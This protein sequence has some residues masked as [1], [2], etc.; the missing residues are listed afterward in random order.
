MSRN[1]K[2]TTLVSGFYVLGLGLFVWGAMLQPETRISGT[3]GKRKVDIPVYLQ[4][5]PAYADLK[6]TKVSAGWGGGR[7]LLWV[8][9]ASSGIIGLVLSS[10][11]RSEL[12]KEQILYESECIELDEQAKLDRAYRLSLDKA[13]KERTGKAAIALHEDATVAELDSLREAN[14]WVAPP[15]PEAKE[16]LLPPQLKNVP[17]SVTDYKTQLEE[18][19]AAARARLTKEGADDSEECDRPS[20][21]ADTRYQLY[22]DRGEK[23]MRSL[24]ALKMSILSAAPT[25]AGKTH[26][27]YRWLGDLQA[28]YPQNECYVIAHKRDSF[29]G[30]LEQNRVKL[31]DDLNPEASLVFLDKVY[32]EMKRRLGKPENERKKF[33]KLPIRLILDDW[34][35]SYGVIKLNGP[36]WNEVRVKL[37]AIITKGREANVCLYIA[38]QS[39][40]LEAIG[41]Q[42]SNIRGNLAITCQ[43][44]VT[45]KLDDY[46]DLV[47]QGNYESIQLLI[48]NKFIVSSRV[49]RERLNAELEELIALS[50]LHQV[51][52][53]FSAVGNNTLALAPYYEKPISGDDS[54]STNVA[55]VDKEELRSGVDLWEEFQKEMLKRQQQKTDR[56][57]ELPLSDYPQNTTSN[58]W[59]DAKSSNTSGNTSNQYQDSDN[60]NIENWELQNWY[61]WLPNKEEV[62]KLI[63]SL[64]PIYNLAYV[65]KNRLK[66]TEGFYNRRAKAAIVRLLLDTEREDLIKKLDIDPTLYPFLD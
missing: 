39:F 47:E 13:K 23:I 65:V 32:E 21:A 58:G 9:G 26:T 50:R 44:L 2:A 11:R 61:K 51:P 34:F 49:D 56:D 16:P 62:I 10:E 30:L 28:L 53:M 25:G 18:L 63:E 38:T 4:S 46:G 6:N 43:G 8:V 31:F 36:L 35:A 66:K 57:G 59:N 60:G 5:E 64:E 37:G 33:E 22:Q 3:I 54:I 27:L 7:L 55:V 20:I 24:V 41:I 40:N 29:L 48:D 15:L 12:E 14:G 1:Q 17:E 42:D 19:V 52:A 45:E